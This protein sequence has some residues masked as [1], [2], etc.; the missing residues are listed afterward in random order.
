MVMEV[1][2]T[3]ERPPNKRLQPSAAGAIMGRR[4]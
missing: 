1:S 3:L 4:G 2:V